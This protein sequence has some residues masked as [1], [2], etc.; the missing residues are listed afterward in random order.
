M[1]YCDEM[2]RC[3]GSCQPFNRLLNLQL[4]RVQKSSCC[5]FNTEDEAKANTFVSHKDW[6]HSTQELSCFFKKKIPHV[7]YSAHAEI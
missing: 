3:I 7:P 5:F 4:S 6:A 2:K 1:K